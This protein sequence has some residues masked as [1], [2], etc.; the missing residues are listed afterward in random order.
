MAKQKKHLNEEKLTAQAV[1]FAK[2]YL[3]RN[4]L[5]NLPERERRGILNGALAGFYAG[6]RFTE[7]NEEK[8]YEVNKDELQ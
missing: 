4:K 3:N 7:D 5:A 8:L 2:A 6:V 1:D